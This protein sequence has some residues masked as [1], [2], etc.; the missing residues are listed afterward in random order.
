MRIDP[1]PTVRGT[2]PP[3]HSSG[4]TTGKVTLIVE[5]W[6]NVRFSGKCESSD[7]IVVLRRLEEKPDVL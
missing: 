2:D 7:S 5:I 4:A 3:N 1:A 6:T